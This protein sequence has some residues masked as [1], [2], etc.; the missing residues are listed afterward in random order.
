MARLFSEGAVPELQELYLS[1]NKIG[2]AGFQALSTALPS[3]LT[4]LFLSGNQIGDAGLQALSTALPPELTQLWLSSC[5][6]RR[7]R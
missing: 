1:R 5:T 6:T 7:S 4:C 2:D 3:K